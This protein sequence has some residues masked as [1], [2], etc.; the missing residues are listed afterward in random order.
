M[1]NP[2]LVWIVKLIAVL[3]LLQTLYF[4]FTAAEESVYIFSTLG[5]EPYG[6][7]GSGIIELIASILIIIPRTTLFGAL[8]GFGTMLGAI[9]SHLLILGIEVKNDGGLLFILA[10]ITITCCL[11][12]VYFEKIKLLISFIKNV[13]INLKCPKVFYF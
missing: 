7:I 1:K 9:A 4:K 11:I 5:V 8:L 12:L 10:T 13:K 6:R 2:I 3:I